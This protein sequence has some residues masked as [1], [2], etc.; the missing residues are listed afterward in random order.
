MWG[1]PPS[2]AGNARPGSSRIIMNDTLE[3]TLRKTTG[4]S[5]ARRL[6]RSGG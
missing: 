5:E 1:F 4:S 6:R 2:T 3:V